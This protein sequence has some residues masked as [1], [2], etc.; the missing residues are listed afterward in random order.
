MFDA[1]VVGGSYAGQSAALQLARARR[2]VLVVDGGK[3]RNRFAHESHGFLTQDGADPAEIAARAREQ[4]LKY[5]NVEW[6]DGVAENASGSADAFQ[7]RVS[8]ETVAARRVVLAMG[9]A[10]ELP[11]VPGL[12]ERWGKSVFHC[13]YCHGYELNQ[14]HVGVLGVAP[15]S[16]HHALMLP[17]WG[18]TTFF[19]NDAFEPDAVQLA[20]LEARNVTFERTPVKRIS[21]DRA[22]VELADGRVIALDGLFT[23]TRTSVSSPVAAELGCA[24]EDGPLGTFIQTDTMK[25]T[26]VPGVFACGDAARA[27]GTVAWAVGDGAMAGAATHR[28]LMFGLG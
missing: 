24:F 28:T 17:D 27:A 25:A 15:I 2:K 4:L 19:L 5:P 20:Q 11:P 9:V 18:Q 23:A 12:A 7:L 13:P 16:L 1:V 26:S 14:G 22:D 10:D 3:R 6:R 8:G 21:G